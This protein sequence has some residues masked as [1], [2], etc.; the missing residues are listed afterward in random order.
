MRGTVTSSF[1]ASQASYLLFRR[2]SRSNSL[3]AYFPDLCLE[4][5]WNLL[6]QTRVAFLH[7]FRNFLWSLCEWVTYLFT[8]KI[9]PGQE[10]NMLERVD[11]LRIQARCTYREINSGGEGGSEHRLKNAPLCSTKDKNLKMEMAGKLWG[12]IIF[13]ET[14]WIAL[15]PVN[16]LITKSKGINHVFCISIMSTCFWEWT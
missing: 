16:N 12:D 14:E 8:I 9:P 3:N 1:P 4:G 5:H 2:R 10:C 11:K 7:C 13:F 6:S 15:K